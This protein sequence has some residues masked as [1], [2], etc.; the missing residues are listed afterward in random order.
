MN[1]PV[2][3][4][5]ANVFHNSTA[6]PQYKQSGQIIECPVYILSSCCRDRDTKALLPQRFTFPAC[7]PSPPLPVTFLHLHNTFSLILV[8]S[9]QT[10]NQLFL[11]LRFPYSIDD[12]AVLFNSG[13]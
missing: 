11:F 8:A 5:A 12:I 6:D 4:Y 2:L 10:L 7:H 1:T 9:M 3:I 13:L